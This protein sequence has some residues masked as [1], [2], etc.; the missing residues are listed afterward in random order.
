MNI[1]Y[2]HDNPD[3]LEVYITNDNLKV[4]ASLDLMYYNEKS[5]LFIK[6]IEVLKNLKFD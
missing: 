6:K 4:N 3:K 2:F 1:K 5:R